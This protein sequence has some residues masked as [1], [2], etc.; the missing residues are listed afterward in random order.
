MFFFSLFLFD[1]NITI[2]LSYYYIVLSY[3]YYYYYY[4]YYIT[5]MRL[6]STKLHFLTQ[7]HRALKVIVHNHR[8]YL[9]PSS[10]LKTT[11]AKTTR[12]QKMEIGPN[13]SKKDF[14]TQ[15]VQSM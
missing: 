15:A 11:S 3:Y 14:I 4:Y 10:I 8:Q 13:T 12:R 7:M 6:F 2:V 1:F 9:R 5:N